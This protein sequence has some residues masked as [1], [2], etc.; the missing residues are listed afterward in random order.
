MKNSHGHLFNYQ[1]IPEEIYFGRHGISHKKMRIIMEIANY[2][3]NNGIP[4]EI[5]DTIKIIERFLPIIGLDDEWAQIKR[6][7]KMYYMPMNK[8]VKYYAESVLPNAGIDEMCILIPNFQDSH[9][10]DAVDIISAC[11]KPYKQFK[12]FAPLEYIKRK[13]VY[14]VKYYPALEGPPDKQ[15]WKIVA[16]LGKPIISHSSPGGVRSKYIPEELAK[17]YNAPGKWYDVLT[18]LPLRLCLAHCGGRRAFVYWFTEGK[19][20]PGNWPYDNMVRTF[21]GIEYPGKVWVDIAFHEAQL[22]ADYRK[23]IMNIDCYWKD[24]I[25]FGVDDPL[26]ET[27]Y[28]IVTAAKW[29]RENFDIEQLDNNYEDFVK[30]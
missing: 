18:K 29:C 30:I 27:Q 21:D 28:S 5:E 1:T 11:I 26:Q 12:L 3:K 19:F 4:Q 10:R 6:I 17:K 16:D 23:A 14:G 9:T 2:L 13:D 15:D 20:K 25:L 24:R 7:L 8:L 22:D